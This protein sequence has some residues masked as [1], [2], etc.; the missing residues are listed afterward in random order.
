[1][2]KKITTRAQNFSTWY[3]DVIDAADLADQSPVR[4]CVTF[5]PHGFAV[6]EN[7]Q[8]KLDRAFKETGHRNAYFPMLMPES[9]IKKEQ[10]HIKGFSPELA[11]VTHAGGKKLDEPLVVRPTSEAIIGYMM[12]KWIKSY[13]DLPLLLNQWCNVIRWEMRPRIFLRTSEFLWQEG[14]TAHESKQE[15]EQ[16]TLQMLEIYRK[17]LVEDCLIPV[18]TGKKPAHEKFPGALTT[19]SLE[20]LMQDGKA[21][22]AGTSHNLGQNFS[23]VFDIKYLNQENKQEHAWTTS[24][25]VSTRVIGG[26]VMVHG[27]DDGVIFPPNIAPVK[28]VLVP[29]WHNDNEEGQ[30]RTMLDDCFKSLTEFIDPWQIEID[31][32][33]NLRPT[34]RFFHWVR[35]GVPIRI[36]IGAN[37]V[38]A[39]QLSIVLRHNRQKISIS[40]NEIKSCVKNAIKQINK[41]LYE[42]ALKFRDENLTRTDDYQEFKKII[43]N[44]GGFVYAHWDGTT[45]T[46]EKIKNETK[47]TIRVIPNELEIETGRCII[48]NK[49]SP[50]RVL[51]AGAY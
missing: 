48:T 2:A 9:F 36:V 42:R 1:M 13:R 33:H 45:E 38:K 32:Q 49:P 20:A 46:A 44:K 22:Q 27:D 7:V 37:E 24:W 31:N 41:E 15:A 35:K 14:H 12:A 43:K 50:R 28:V 47:A 25:G 4:G 3:Q 11:V 51:F 17:F 18:F 23:K 19:H 6:W 30:V 26:L 5:K 29:I 34:E 16:E 21:L 8:Q 39:N 40:P 10:E